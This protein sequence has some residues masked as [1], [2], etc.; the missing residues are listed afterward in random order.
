MALASI[1]LLPAQAQQN[2]I[3][4]LYVAA[5]VGPP[6]LVGRYSTRAKCLQAASLATR[7]LIALNRPSDQP[8]GAAVL[9]CVPGGS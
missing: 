1:T 2:K 8:Q 3:S 4:S 9:F 5:G 6:T 7:D